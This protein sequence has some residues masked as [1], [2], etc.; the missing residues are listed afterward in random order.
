MGALLGHKRKQQRPTLLGLQGPVRTT[1]LLPGRV[2]F[3][4]RKLRG[5]PTATSDLAQR[6]GR[7]EGVEAVE[8]SPVSGSV[9]L[10]YDEDPLR[11]DLLLAAIVR[12]LGLERELERPPTPLLVQELRSA[13][14]ALNHAVYERS[15]GLIDLWTAIPLGMVLVG[16][17]RMATQRSAML[18]AGLTLVWWGYNSLFLKGRPNR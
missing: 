16:I 1:H 6:L 13:G 12:L 4:V 17:H 15:G 3:Q 10:R 2:R 7:I 5:D 18:P 8:A 14:D 9:L 11:A